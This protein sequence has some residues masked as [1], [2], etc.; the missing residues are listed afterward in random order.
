MFVS[1]V[2]KALLNILTLEIMR[3]H[4]LMRNHINAVYVGKPSLFVLTLDIMRTVTLY[5]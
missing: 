4:T 1:Y 3:K 2:G 5:M